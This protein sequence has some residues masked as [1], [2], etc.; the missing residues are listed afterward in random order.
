MYAFITMPIE[1]RGSI[2]IFVAIDPSIKYDRI[3]FVRMTGNR[4]AERRV[5]DRLLIPF[6]RF[7]TWHGRETIAVS[8]NDKNNNNTPVRRLWGL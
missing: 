1:R 8:D 3:S 7:F 4:E 5:E 2:R 6:N